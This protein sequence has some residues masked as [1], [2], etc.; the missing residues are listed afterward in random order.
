TVFFDRSAGKQKT[1]MVSHKVDGRWSQPEVAGF[2][3]HAFD[4]DP[5]MA[6]DGSY[7]LF[8]SDRPPTKDSQPLMQDYFVGGS[9]PGSNIWRMNREGD[10]WS[11]PSWLGSVVNNDVFIDF[12]SIAA[13][14]SLYFIGCDARP[15]ARSSWS[16]SSTPRSSPTASPSHSARATAG[17]RCRI[18]AMVSTAARRTWAPSSAPTARCP[19]TATAR[20]PARR[21]T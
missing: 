17:A 3:G 1:I 20:P 14:G 8:D 11:Q 12:A 2:S 16:A 21:R 13:D 5:V 10:G 19:S 6:P 4:Q 15:T 18:S 7:L 9:G